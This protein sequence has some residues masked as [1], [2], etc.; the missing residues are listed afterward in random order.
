M[1]L[2]THRP[3]ISA[4]H[5]SGDNFCVTGGNY[6]SPSV[7]NA[8]GPRAAKSVFSIRSIVEENKNGVSSSSGLSDEGCERPF[9]AGSSR[10]M[11]I[12]DKS[13]PTSM[14]DS[15]VRAESVP[16]FRLRDDMSGVSGLIGKAHHSSTSYGRIHQ[17]LQSEESR[18]NSGKRNISSDVTSDDLNST[19]SNEDVNDADHESRKGGLGHGDGDGD[20]EAAGSD[21]DHPDEF[22][23]KRKQRRYRTTFTS[24]QLEELEKAFSRTHYPD[25]FT[26]EELAMKIGLTEARIQV[27]FQNRRA[28]WR[29]QE[30][31]G[32]QGH[33]YSPYGGAASGAGGANGMPT[34]HNHHHSHQLGTG[35]SA[36]GSNGGSSS[37]PLPVSLGGPHPFPVHL[38]SNHPYMPRKSLDFLTRLPNLPTSPMVHGLPVTM[39]NLHGLSG[40]PPG[41]LSPGI[42]SPFFGS[43]LH[44]YRH[45][46][47]NSVYSQPNP[48]MA[49]HSFQALLASLSNQRPKLATELCPNDYQSLLCRLSTLHQSTS[50]T[51]LTS[52]ASPPSHHPVSLQQPQVA[53]AG[54]APSVSPSSAAASSCSP[55][56]QSISACGNSNSSSGGNVELPPAASSPLGGELDR[57]ASSIA[58][59]R[60]KAREH[61]L[62]IE[63]MRKNGTDLLS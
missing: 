25:V 37:L 16:D 53:Q 40:M 10:N 33:P 5:H 30:K 32:P 49:A 29:K 42:G 38:G 2:T 50:P 8:P 35:V 28:K 15:A 24:Y 45:P 22:T 61:E 54:A 17:S 41:Y 14:E 34:L 1:D 19:A 27:W 18:N 20:G 52:L 55:V 56:P 58:A 48:S 63:M 43:A 11:G 23:P 44:G 21:G 13:A 51:G 9:L 12:Y 7:S 36:S 62:R 3:D 46:L 39:A 57:R 60:L 59:L 47:V 6:V 26:R 31:V 4:V